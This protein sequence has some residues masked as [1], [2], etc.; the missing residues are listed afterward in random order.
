MVPGAGTWVDTGGLE[1]RMTNLAEPPGVASVVA[2]S[3]D[4]M[5][6]P[7]KVDPATL[8]SHC[9]RLNLE[10]RVAAG[11]GLRLVRGAWT[12]G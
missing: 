1:A 3:N 7:D 11:P 6:A 9:L 4:T 12:S 8:M 2:G 10:N 5:P